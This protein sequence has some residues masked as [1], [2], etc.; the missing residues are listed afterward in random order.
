MANGK[1]EKGEAGRPL[2]ERGVST[3]VDAH[4]GPV[5]ITKSGRVDGRSRR[6]TNRFF[7]VTWVLQPRTHALLDAIV[8]RDGF[9][10]YAVLLEVMLTAYMKQYGAID[11][12]QLPTDAELMTKYL[13]QRDLDDGKQG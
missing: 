13:E 9:P 6:R 5:R 7:K 1:D 12:S 3:P 10:S 4:Y 8:E 2:P 11:E